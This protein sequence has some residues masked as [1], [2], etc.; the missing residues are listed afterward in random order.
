M[1]NLLNNW[2]KKTTYTK[3]NN[4]DYY[5]SNKE[6]I[7]MNANVIGLWLIDSTGLPLINRSYNNSDSSLIDSALFSGFITAIVAFSKQVVK[8]NIETIE[9]GGHS[10]HYISFDQFSVVST[11]TKTSIANDL[12]PVMKQIG[13][14][15]QSLYQKELDQIARDT[16][17]FIDFESY[18]DEALGQKQTA[19]QKSLNDFEIGLILTEVKF[20]KITPSEAIDKIYTS[21]KRLDKKSQAFIREAMK[22]F[23]EFFTDTTGLSKDEI[24]MFKEIVGKMTALMKSEKFF[25]AF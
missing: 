21:F 4:K 19:H 2:S 15:F 20:N 17:T 16:N 3:K 10:I 13:N 5:K 25:Q 24:S 1:I 14:K 18:I 22:D 12:H 7:L 11:T 9:M 8:D 23:E 6:L